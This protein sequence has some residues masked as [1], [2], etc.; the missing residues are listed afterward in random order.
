MPRPC[1]T[2]SRVWS[3]AQAVHVAGDAV[4]VIRKMRAI[5]GIRAGAALVLAAVRP[6]QDVAMAQEVAAGFVPAPGSLVAPARLSMA[7]G[8]STPDVRADAARCRTWLEVSGQ[9]ARGQPARSSVCGMS[10]GLPGGGVPRRGDDEE[11]KCS[12][13]ASSCAWAITP[14][15]ST[16]STAMGPLMADD[17]MDSSFSQPFFFRGGG[18]GGSLIA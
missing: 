11:T 10:R 7:E 9:A 4:D 8:Y 17:R 15:A 13:A 1:D 2:P 6:A 18:K 12:A 16:A 3:S 14:T 5:G